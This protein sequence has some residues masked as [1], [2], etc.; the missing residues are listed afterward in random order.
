MCTENFAQ[1]GG[2]STKVEIYNYET[3]VAIKLVE[4]KSQTSTEVAAAPK[5][6]GLLDLCGTGK[7]TMM[8]L[9]MTRLSKRS[10]LGAMM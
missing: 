4:N 7:P 8:R 2:N 9:L 5:K 1:H 6:N 10:I 3:E